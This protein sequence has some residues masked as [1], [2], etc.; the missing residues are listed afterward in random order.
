MA[1]NAS[2]TLEKARVGWSSS[3]RH[4]HEQ[5][6]IH[7]ELGSVCC[8]VFASQTSRCPDM[9]IFPIPSSKKGLPRCFTPSPSVHTVISRASMISA[10]EQHLYYV[11]LGAAAAM[12]ASKGRGYDSGLIIRF[13]RLALEE[14]LLCICSKSAHGVT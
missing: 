14:K 11:V 10:A 6:I 7:K 2:G 3:R 5:L 12:I 9:A 13:I 8:L 4:Y 1:T